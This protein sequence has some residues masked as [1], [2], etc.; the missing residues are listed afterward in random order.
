M[1]TYESLWAEIQGRTDCAEFI[2]PSE[3]KVS[4]DVARAGDAA[5]AAL[6]SEGRKQ[7]VSRRVSVREII[8]EYP[9]G[10]V[11]ADAVL[12]K[13]DSYAA[14]SEP[15]SRLVKRT[16]P[17]LQSE[18]GLDLGASATRT[19]IEALVELHVLTADEGVKLKSLAEIQDIVTPE[20]VSRA[21]RG[22]RS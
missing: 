2:V 22:P 8:A 1:T 18:S 20:D 4:A 7:I 9:D 6:L 16:L 17:F 14:A 15:L 5:I 19:M 13:L 12:A 11:A 3:P 10:P 21:V